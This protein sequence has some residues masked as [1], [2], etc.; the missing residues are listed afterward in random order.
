ME[1]EQLGMALVSSIVMVGLSKAVM[2][3]MTNIFQVVH[4]HIEGK[5]KKNKWE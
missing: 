1:K 4:V 2:E 5:S 3:I